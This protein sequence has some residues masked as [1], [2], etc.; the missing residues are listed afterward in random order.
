[1]RMI[2]ASALETLNEDYVRTARAKGAPEWLV[3]RSYVLRNAMLPVVTM[4]GM[5]IAVSLGATLFVETA[6]TGE[7]DVASASRSRLLSRRQPRSPRPFVVRGRAGADDGVARL[8]VSEQDRRRDREHAVARRG[9]GVLVDVELCERDLAAGLIL[10]RRQH[11]LDRVTGAAPG[12]PEVD[13]DRMI[14]PED[15]LF[16][17]VVGH[18]THVI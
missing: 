11:G 8:A 13:D 17:T 12:S 10:E 3:I 5:D 9:H 7:R 14:R 4:L 6:S 18:I 1:M 15:I 16:E 2:R